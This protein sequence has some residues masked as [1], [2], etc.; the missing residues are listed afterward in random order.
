M[1]LVLGAFD[2]DLS[3]ERPLQDHERIMGARARQARA[4]REELRRVVGFS[5]ADEIGKLDQL[6]RAGS[7]TEGEFARLRAR[8][9]Q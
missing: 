6:R 5:V 1:A 3:R 8:L 4:A 2:L 9:V 7:I